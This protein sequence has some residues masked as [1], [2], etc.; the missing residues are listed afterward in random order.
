M[1]RTSALT[2]YV[3]ALITSTAA[4]ENKSAI[5]PEATTV[6]QTVTRA[7]QANDLAALRKTMIK[8]FTW[9]FGGDRDADQAIEAWRTDAEYIKS[10]KE[11]LRTDCQLE[12]STHI[13][14]SGKGENDFRAGFEKTKSGWKFVYFVAGD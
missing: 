1:R 14:C 12:D 3:L 4:A 8:D 6:I 7:A 9:S 13:E 5:P 10:L 11:V 2:I